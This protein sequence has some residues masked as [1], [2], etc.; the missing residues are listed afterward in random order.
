MIWRQREPIVTKL[1][2]DRTEQLKRNPD[3]V[4]VEI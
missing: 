3:P 1:A 4:A 2:E